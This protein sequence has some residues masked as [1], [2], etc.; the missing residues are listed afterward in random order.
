LLVLKKYKKKNKNKNLQKK[1]LRDHVT[2]PKFLAIFL[3]IHDCFYDLFGMDLDDFS[4]NFFSL[5][6]PHIAGQHAPYIPLPT[7][8]Y[9]YK[10]SPLFI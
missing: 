4:L 5:S 6:I 2:T 1:K 8:L 9:I 3:K 10:F 7:C